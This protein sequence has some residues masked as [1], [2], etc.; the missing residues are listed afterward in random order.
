MIK[1]NLI[2]EKYIS[3]KQFPKIIV[4]YKIPEVKEKCICGME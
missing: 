3:K 1:L 4:E 2:S